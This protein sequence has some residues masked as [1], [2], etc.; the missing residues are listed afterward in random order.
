MTQTTPITFDQALQ[1]LQSLPLEQQ[2]ALIIAMKEQRK[3]E[4]ITG[5]EEAEQDFAEGRFVR[6]NAKTILEALRK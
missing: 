5:V 2:D 3:T 6:G 4:F 1:M